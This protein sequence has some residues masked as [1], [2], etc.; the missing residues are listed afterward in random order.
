MPQVTMK[1]IAA[2]CGVSV[3]TVSN[4]FNRPDQL[5]GELRTRILAR[6]EKM[7]Y[8]GPDARGRSLRVGRS[9]TYGVVFAERL[10]YAFTDPFCSEW[11]AGFSQVMER[12]GASIVLLSVP[13]GDPAAVDTVQRTPLDGLAGL[14]GANAA[15][16][17]ARQRGIPVIVGSADATGETVTID[18]VAA[19]REL[20]RYLRRL[21]HRRVSVVVE[22]LDERAET[23][24][25]LD[26]PGFH[27]LLDR[28]D[29]RSFLDSWDRWRGFFDGLDGAEI[30]VVVAGLNTRRSGAEAGQVL[31]DR[32]DRS[33]AVLAVSDVLAL[34]VLDAMA[35]RGL[36]PGRDV[37]VAGFDDLPGLAEAAG[38]TTM[39]QP[40]RERGRLTAELLL[41]PAR[42]PRSIT[43]PCRLVIRRSTGPAPAA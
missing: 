32:A 34:G 7:G 15:I 6:A 9:N 11:L 23:P 37:S 14:C 31:F 8:T 39:R 35:Q 19:G 27:A 12:R 2:V 24:T 25:E 36:A 16:D 40:I 1:D 26:L 20:G 17:A 29:H 41:D 3:M 4:A 5:S 18:D 21:G 30:R 10:S 22:T 38:L 13:V 33:T 42:R 43:L 28:Q